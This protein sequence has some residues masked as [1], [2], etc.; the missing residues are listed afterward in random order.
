M[1]VIS[2]LVAMS[3]GVDS[4]V[5][6]L[7]AISQ[8]CR[9][10]GATMRLFPN[11]ACPRS[12]RGDAEDAAAA[13]RLLGISHQVLDLAAEF[14]LRVIDRFIRTYEAGGTPNPCVDCNRWLKFGALLNAARERGL[15]RV[16]TGHY[17]R[18]ERDGRS[19]RYLL[20]KAADGARDQSYAL[21]SLTQDQLARALFPLGGMT[22]AQVRDLARD[23]GLANA[24]K[25]D[26]QDICFVPDGDYAG[27]IEGYTGR[28][29]PPGDFVDASGRVLGRH[30]GL[31]RYTIGQRR[32]LGGVGGG[33]LYVSGIDP[34]A[35]RVI[36][37]GEE[38]LFFR[39]VWA[40]DVNLIAVP[41][42][43]TP[44]RVGVKLRYRQEEAPATVTRTGEDRLRI[45]FDEPQ[46]AP[47]AGQAAV[48]YDGDV[49]VGGG[50]ICGAE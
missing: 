19:G 27:F 4:S 23:H 12:A 44:L 42:I 47:A 16:V 13:A 38:A 18:V 7:L 11:E 40:E 50:T 45:D 32:G 15:E 17:A 34:A 25:R 9:C 21:Y 33:R 36:L 49:V 22:K 39:T 46:R 41:D 31:I 1:N 48:L 28:A 35:N 26:S 14:R 20:K 30:R 8:G 3:G 37:S 6:A 10:L 24:D 2:A 29:H 5:A 43:E